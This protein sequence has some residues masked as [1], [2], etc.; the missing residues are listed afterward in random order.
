MWKGKSTGSNTYQWGG[1]LTNIFDY[2]L[3]GFFLA[4]YKYSNACMAFINHNKC[5]AQ[6]VIHG[7]NYADQHILL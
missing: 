1:K 5:D 7:C 3:L 6:G 4:P 2:L